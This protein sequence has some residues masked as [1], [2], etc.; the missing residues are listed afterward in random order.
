MYADSTCKG[1]A[2]SGVDEL[3]A[4][5]AG[6]V[7]SPE[8][9][10]AA[11]EGPDGEIRGSRGSHKRMHNMDTPEGP[12]HQDLASIPRS[13][14]QVAKQTYPLLQRRLPANR[15]REHRNNRAHGEVAVVGGVLRMGDH[16]PLK[17][18]MSGELGNAGKRGQGGKEN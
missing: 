6:A 13:L 10:S 9:K 17:K 11:P 3:Q 16:R 7:R 4:L 12:L 1:N 15:M 18:A 8:G 5:H 2:D 14:V